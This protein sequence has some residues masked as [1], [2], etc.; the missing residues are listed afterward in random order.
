MT[1][2]MRSNLIFN[3]VGSLPLLFECCKDDLDP[4]AAISSFIW[5][6]VENGKGFLFDYNPHPLLNE[7]NMKN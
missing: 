3:L 4:F 2:M 5:S 7:R 6:L 1:Q